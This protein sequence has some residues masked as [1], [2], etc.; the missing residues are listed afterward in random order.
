LCGC[1]PDPGRGPGDQTD[2]ALHLHRHILL[3]YRLVS[4]VPCQSVSPCRRQKIVSPTRRPCGSGIPAYAGIL[5]RRA[6]VCYS[7]A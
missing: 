1:L 3:I 6:L 4:V 7:Y 5:Y 2:L